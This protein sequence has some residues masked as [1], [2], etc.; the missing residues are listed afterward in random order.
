MK[1]GLQRGFVS[2][3][4][5]VME[6]RGTVAW[7]SSGGLNRT[8]QRKKIGYLGFSPGAQ[9]LLAVVEA[10]HLPKHA[11]S[12]RAL[13]T[14]ALGTRFLVLMK[15]LAGFCKGTGRRPRKA[16]PG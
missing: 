11:N 10:S 4:R 16:E 2:V 9:G 12:G 5:N 6:M 14:H 3:V 8:Q 15:A 13:T 1:E 7:G